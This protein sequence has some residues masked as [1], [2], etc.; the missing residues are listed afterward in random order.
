M[1]QSLLFELKCMQTG[2]PPCMALSSVLM[3]WDLLLEPS[4]AALQ[5]IFAGYL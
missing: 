1:L 4:S 2:T 3:S 5:V